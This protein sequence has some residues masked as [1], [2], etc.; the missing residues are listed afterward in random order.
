[1]M[2]RIV[3]RDLLRGHRGGG[4]DLVRRPL[5]NGHFEYLV[6][7]LVTWEHVLELSDLAVADRRAEEEATA[8][9]RRLDN[10]RRAA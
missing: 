9:E 6:K 2:E 4:Y 7:E 10:Q 1:M 5:G 8:E 3:G